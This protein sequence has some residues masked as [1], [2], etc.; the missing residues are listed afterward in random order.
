MYICEVPFQTQ[1]RYKRLRMV[2]EVLTADAI[3]M[4][5][6]IISPGEDARIRDIV[7]KEIA[8]PMDSVRGRPGLVLVSVQP[9]NNDN[10]AKGQDNHC[11][12]RESA[13]STTGLSPP[14]TILRP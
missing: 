6:R 10:T 13:Y 3:A 14:A 4:S 7:W 11:D 1:I 5:I 2:V 8:E 9:M 12:A